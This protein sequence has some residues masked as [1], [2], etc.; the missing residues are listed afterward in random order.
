MRRENIQRG[1]KM[2]KVGDVEISWLGHA[3]FKIKAEG[4]V[5]YI[6]PW[7]LKDPEE[8]TLVLVTHDHFDHCSPED[9]AKIRGEKTVLVTTPDCAAKLKD[10]LR[11][12]APGDVVELDG[13]RIEVVAAYNTD[14]DFHKKESRWVGFV[15]SIGGMRIYHS[16][17]TDIIQE[18]RQ[19]RNITVAL[20]PVSGTYVMTAEQAAEAA[21]IIGAEIFVPMHYGDIVGTE[22]DAER[23]KALCEGLRVEILEKEN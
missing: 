7:K 15:L 10:H 13:L 6:D 21:K 2:L 20:L 11:A 22:K 4:K 18:M 5:I 8:A 17:D 12:I 14:K 3:S 19:L 23:F 9:V 16:G 1:I